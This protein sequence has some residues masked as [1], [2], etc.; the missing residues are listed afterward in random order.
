MYAT[1]DKNGHFTGVVY[2][3]MTQNIQDWHDDAGFAWVVVE[4][5]PEPI[6]EDD[7]GNE[8]YGKPTTE[9]LAATVR[10]HRDHLIE[11]VRWRIE[12]HSDELALGRE[13]TEPLE[14]L[15]Q[16]AQALRDVPQQ[17][18]FPNDIDWPVIPLGSDDAD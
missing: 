4:K 18:G 5:N 1:V 2:S 15:L 11:T 9:Q 8:K 7:L 10:H 3:E 13:P 16:H 6:G 14:P 12:R 17:S